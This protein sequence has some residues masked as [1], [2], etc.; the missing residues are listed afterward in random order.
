MGT[1]E[2]MMNSVNPVR[3]PAGVPEFFIKFL[4]EPN[5]LIVDPFAGS[6]VTGDV[7][8]RLRRRWISFE[9]VEEY[10][11][12]SKY[13]FNEFCFEDWEEHS[14]Q[15][16]FFIREENS[17]YQDINNKKLKNDIRK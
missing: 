5:D 3:Y 1:R 11:K 17:S 4:T 13:R 14:G 9:L 12:G 10:L 15:K 8:E 7:C 2:E 6:N 16:S